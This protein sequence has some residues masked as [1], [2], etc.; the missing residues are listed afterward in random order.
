MK[1]QIFKKEWGTEACYTISGI[2]SSKKGILIWKP[3]KC[4]FVDEWV[5]KMWCLHMYTH[6]HTHT[7]YSYYSTIKKEWNLT[8]CNNMD[9]H[10]GR[11][12]Q[13]SQ[14][15]RQTL[16]DVAYM[17]ALKSD[18]SEQA[19]HDRKSHRH[20]EHTR[21]CERGGGGEEKQTEEVKRCQLP[22]AE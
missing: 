3:S 4:L 7:Q 2:A 21:G 9:G 14:T 8:L 1:I 20:S 19:W 16:Y 18:T 6:T 10:R 22:F 11:Y 12:T 17:W 5:R 13:W 15:E